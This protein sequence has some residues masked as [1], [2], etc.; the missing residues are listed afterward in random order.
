MKDLNNAIHHLDLTDMYR[1]LTQ[2]QQNTEYILLKHTENA[3]IS[4]VEHQTRLK[5]FKK[6]ESYQKSFPV[7]MKWN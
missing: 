2:Q 7:T 5:E 6:T 4:H 3:H 1:T